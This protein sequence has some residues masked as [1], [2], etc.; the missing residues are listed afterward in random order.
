MKKTIFFISFFIL[1]GNFQPLLAQINNQFQIANRLIQQ[2]RYEDALPILERVTNQ[3]PE[4]FIFFDR[5]IECHTQLKQYDTAIDLIKTKINKGE[6]IGQSNILLGKL[7][8]LQGDTTLANSVW[9]N[10]LNQFPNQ[11]QLYLTTADAMMDRK[12]YG[13]AIEVYKKGRIVFKNSQLFMSDI[14]NAY[15]QAGEYENAISEWLEIIKL[16]PQQSSTIQRML[17]RYNDP[18][19]YDITIL[20]LEDQILNMALTDPS[21]TTFY[22]LQ[23]WLLLENKLYRRAFSTAR[24]YESLTSNFNFSLFNVGRKLSENNEFDLSIAAFNY[25]IESSFGEIKWRAEEEKASIYTKWA[26]YLDDYSLDFFG[27]KDSLFH[28]AVE[29]LDNLT[30]QTQTYSRIDKVYLKKAELSLDFVFDIEAAKEATK[31]LKMQPNMYESAE[32]G[33]LDG[34]IYLAQQEYTSARIAFTR[35]NKKAGVGEIAEKTRYFLALTDFYAGDFEFAKIQLK[36]LG[37][38]NTS[39][40]A[41][42]AL[43]LRLWVQEGLAADTTGESL[44]EFANAHY[45]LSVGEKEMASDYLFAIANSEANTPFKD[46]AYLMLTEVTDISTGEYVSKISN[47]LENSP[48]LSLNERLLWERAKI[49]DLTYSTVLNHYTI[50]EDTNYEPVVSDIKI[51]EVIDYYEQLILKY[52]QG[53]YAPYARKRLSELPNPNS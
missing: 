33:Y 9:E 14:P 13:Q 43:E 22:E 41:N 36:S 18:L 42:D 5:L 48:Y 12:E 8:H 37:R 46:D 32:A 11:L 21:Y 3:E 31:L 26:K 2:Q 10:N 4:I 50:S 30:E 34:R 16:N 28:L 38:Q 29:L 20:E 15:M 51:E 44:K 17:L 49:A 7:H 27:K 45:Q 47:Y 6:N 25:Y 35:S 40:Y 19:L 24:E 23:I 52:P 39:F 53:F 1:I